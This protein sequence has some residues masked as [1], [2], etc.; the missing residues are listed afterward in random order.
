MIPLVTPEALEA[1]A[2]CAA[3]TSRPNLC[4]IHI[5][6][7][8][9]L[10]A[11]NGHQLIQLPPP[12]RKNDDYP[13]IL[14]ADA[15]GPPDGGTIIPLAAAKDAAKAAKRIKRNLS[16]L[17]SVA[18]SLNEKSGYLTSTD[19]DTINRAEFRPIDGP[20]PAIAQLWPKAEPVLKIS[21]DAAQLG[22]LLLAFAKVH[23]SSIQ[24]AIVLTFY[25]NGRA[26][27]LENS[28]GSARGLAMP[29]RPSP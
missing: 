1:A 25:E 12:E 22:L 5:T 19:L 17:R 24:P 16:I 13:N 6:P 23:G 3:D 8:G 4:G 14:G 7:D 9:T 27:L 15:H 10:T 29:L 28:D 11:T 21:V 18:V 20:F 2:A 26:I